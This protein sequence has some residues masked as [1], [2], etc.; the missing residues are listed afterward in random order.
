MFKKFLEVERLGKTE[1]E[2]ILNGICH[3]FPK[4]D[5]T[6][7][8]IWVEADGTLSCGS[9][10][11]VLSLEKNN[12]KFYQFTRD[13]SI[14]WDKF[15]HIFPRYRLF[16]EFLVPHTL[17]TYR[18]DIW[19]RFFVFDIF[20]DV[21]LKWVPYEDYFKHLYDCEIDYIPPMCIINNPSI[22]QLEKLLN[23]NNFGV[24]NGLGEG[25]V[26]KNYDFINCFG[27]H[28]QGKLVRSEFTEENSKVFLPSIS[29]GPTQD[30]DEFVEK[31]VIQERTTKLLNK[32]QG[33]DIPRKQVIP[34]YLESLYHEIIQE[35]LYDFVKNCSRK[36]NFRIL[37]YKV[38]SK[39][40]EL[41]PHLFNNSQAPA[42]VAITEVTT[43]TQAQ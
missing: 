36:I 18:E 37:R 7:G 42:S 23:S 5:G 33:L 35:E 17:K 43:P 12:F 21:G 2:G 14:K 34:R 3:V 29:K 26:I 31:F 8:S 41:A 11:S 13:N 19:N 15:F 40:K 25:I 32:L 27:H 20:D 16:G 1:V 6:N 30:E 22:E 28:A 10:N 4:L 9:R 39:G 38:I 24:K